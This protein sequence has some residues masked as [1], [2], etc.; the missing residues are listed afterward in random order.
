MDNREYPKVRR[1]AQRQGW[2]VVPTAHGEM[3][4][5]PDGRSKVMWHRAHTSSDPNALNS[6]VRDMRRMGF[7]WPPP[8]ETT[9]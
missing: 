9:R 3:L 7:R 5:A 6:L 4:L 1:A 2:S 8:K